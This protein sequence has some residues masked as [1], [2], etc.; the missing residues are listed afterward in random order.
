MYYARILDIQKKLS[1]LF[2]F[3]PDED[4][5]NKKKIIAVMDASNVSMVCSKTATGKRILLPFSNKD[6]NEEIP[7][8]VFEK[9]GASKFS[10][11]YLKKFMDILDLFEDESVIITSALEHPII[12]E[13]EHIKFILAP[14]VD[15]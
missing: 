4:W 7:K 10:L 3:Q 13:N 15:R 14:R 2:N 1:K 11:E 12:L 8:L 5:D 6:N 9:C